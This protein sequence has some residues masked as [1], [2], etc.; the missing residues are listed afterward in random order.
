[1]LVEVAAGEPWDDFVSSCVESDLAGV[2][3]LSGIP[4]SAGATPI[5]NV[6]A[7]GQEV[8]GAIASVRAFDRQTG[9]SLEM[10]PASCAFAYRSSRFNTTERDRY[11]VLGV[12]FALVPRGAP[13]LRHEALQGLFRPAA[14]PG[15][16]EVRDAVRAIRREKGMLLVE[17]DPERRSAGSFFKNPVVTEARHR[18][19]SAEER[20]DLPAF[21][22]GEGR[23]KLPAAWLIER[24]GIRRGMTH[25]GAG[26]STRHALALVNRG[27]ATARDLLSLAEEI[28]RVVAARFAVTLELEPV[29]LGFD[30]FG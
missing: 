16:R 17:G 9:L 6:G 15:L 12:T 8:S 26:V 24:A 20:V 29:L 18:E 23:V 13:A 3:C 30:D 14:S 21:P 25:G 2:E 10:E 11:I 4:G 28:R 7:Y 27:T 22:A 5:Q 19:I 1:V